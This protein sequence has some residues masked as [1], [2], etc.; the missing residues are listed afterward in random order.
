MWGT[1]IVLGVVFA[2]MVWQQIVD[3]DRRKMQRRP[4][5]EVPETA[6]AAVK[7]GARVRIKGRAVA[8]EALRT[9]P[10]SYQECVGYRLTIERFN[11]GDDDQW[12][13][14]VEQDELATFAISDGS[15]EAVLHA[16]FELRLPSTGAEGRDLPRAV[17]EALA[18]ADVARDDFFGMP[19]TF[20]Y[21]ETVV[22]P[23][24]EIIAVG[25]ARFEIDP[26]VRAPSHREPPVTC[27]LKGSDEAVILASVEQAWTGSP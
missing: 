7:D 4:L 23:G 1:L 10:I 17:V 18:N 5:T 16:P 8:R 3:H 25:F 20:R 15:G 2:A 13:K 26:V 24:D 22:L 19:N 14:V 6:I 21:A 12:T 27:H 9:S 11:G